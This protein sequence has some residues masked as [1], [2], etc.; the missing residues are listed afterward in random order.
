MRQVELSPKEGGI[1]MEVG[2]CWTLPLTAMILHFPFLADSYC[3]W[4]IVSLVSLFCPLLSSGL[5]FFTCYCFHCL[6]SGF[7]YCSPSFGS[8]IVCICISRPQ[9]VACTPASALTSIYSPLS[10]PQSDPPH[11][12]PLS[13]PNKAY[14][15]VVVCY[16]IIRVC[17]VLPQGSPDSTIGRGSP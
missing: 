6:L 17:T 11:S 14:R 16:N 5:L 9:L 3:S 2:T 1:V 4:F 10:L 8:I 15:S 12:H 7:H 13:H